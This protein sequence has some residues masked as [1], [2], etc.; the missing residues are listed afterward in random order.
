MKNTTDH[1]KFSR[2]LLWLHSE[3]GKAA[4]EAYESVRVRL[5]KMFYARGCRHR[6]EDLA[7]ET[8]E[9]VM[10]KIDHLAENYEGDRLPYFYAVAKLVFLEYTRKP[11]VEGL[12]EDFQNTLAAEEKSAAEAAGDISESLYGGRLLKCLEKL[13]PAERELVLRYYRTKS[14]DRARLAEEFEISLETLRVRIFRT[15][16]KLKKCVLRSIAGENER[17]SE[18][19][20]K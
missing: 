18:L 16:N 3:D 14:E 5:I 20:R 12:P 11:S 13:K 8:I 4:G 1:E 7:D 2:L 17:K 6:A 15:R 9:R 19:K 10:K